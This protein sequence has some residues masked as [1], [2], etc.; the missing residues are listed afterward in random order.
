MRHHFVKKRQPKHKCIAG[1]SFYEPICL[2]YCVKISYFISTQNI[3]HTPV[4]YTHLDVYKRQLLNT[5]SIARLQ[6][7]GSV[8]AFEQVVVKFYAAKRGGGSLQRL[9]VYTLC[10]SFSLSL[11]CFCT[12]LHAD[13][14]SIRNVHCH[15]FFFVHIFYCKRWIMVVFF[16]YCIEY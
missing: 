16:N 6:Y 5:K 4:S 7:N 15:N 2:I 10:V 1:E 3:S 11:P 12:L 8:E 13:I 9:N 14:I